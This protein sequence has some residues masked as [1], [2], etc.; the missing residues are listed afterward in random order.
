MRIFFLGNEPDFVMTHPLRGCGVHPDAYNTRTGLELQSLRGFIQG[1]DASESGVQV[2]HCQ[3]GAFL[4]HSLQ[5]G[6]GIR[7]R[8]TSALSVDAQTR[9]WRDS[10]ARVRLLDFTAE[11]RFASQAGMV[12]LHSLGNIGNERLDNLA[13]AP[14]NSSSKPPPS[15]PLY[16]AECDSPSRNARCRWPCI[17]EYIAGQHSGALTIRLQRRRG[18]ARMFAQQF[19]RASATHNTH[20]GGIHLKDLVFVVQDHSLTGALRRAPGTFPPTRAA[21]LSARLRSVLS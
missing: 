15:A 2:P 9:S 5:F 13:S 8:A 10:S 21:P 7:A 6:T 12:G 16:P 17:L 1:P 18:F 20:R 3:L 4:E 11:F 14:L 19:L